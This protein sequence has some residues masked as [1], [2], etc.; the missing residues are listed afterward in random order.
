VT[1][2]LLPPRLREE[3]G[4]A[5]GTLERAIS[6]TSIAALRASWWLLPGA[7][8]YLPAYREAERRIAGRPGRD[9]VGILLDQLVWLTRA[10]R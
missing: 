7:L 6:E 4:L 2:H 10:S 8:R 9:P 5:F 1:A 3:F